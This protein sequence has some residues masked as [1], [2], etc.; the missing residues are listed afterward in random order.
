M[1]YYSR[2]VFRAALSYRQNYN[3]F[4]CEDEY[5]NST[6]MS[7]LANSIFLLQGLD[8]RGDLRK[9]YYE[10]FTDLSL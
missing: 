7:L 2:D 6:G 8:C 10:H 9:Y 3:A 4:V 1:N 5:I